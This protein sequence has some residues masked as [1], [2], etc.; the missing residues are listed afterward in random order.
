LLELGYQRL[1]VTQDVCLLVPEVVEVRVQR[2][3]EEPKLVVCQFDGVHDRNSTSRR[4]DEM[5]A[6]LLEA[7]PQTT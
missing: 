3:L 7:G 5:G 6:R 1:D 2:V 4:P